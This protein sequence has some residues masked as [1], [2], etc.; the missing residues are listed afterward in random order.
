LNKYSPALNPDPNTSLLTIE[1]PCSP[2]DE[3]WAM[4]D[5]RLTELC[6][7]G[8]QKLGILQT[9]ARGVT[10]VFSR[11]DEK[12]YPVCDLG[13][14]ERFEMIYNRLNRL[15]NLYTI[16]RGALFLHCNIDH[17]ML[18]AIKLAQHLEHNHGNKDRWEAIRQDFF[19]YRVRE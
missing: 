5:D 18:M 12:V 3:T 19:D 16:G 14:K 8:L 9:P 10:T 2:G 4:A 1:I 11:K 13:W 6:V 7:A 17:C 15:D